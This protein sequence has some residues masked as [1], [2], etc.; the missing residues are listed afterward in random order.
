[1][2]AP[3][4]CS[5][6]TPRL[7]HTR[8]ADCVPL[9]TGPRVEVHVLP[10]ALHGLAHR[11]EPRNATHGDQRVRLGG[12]PNLR[13]GMQ[14]LQVALKR[15]E[16]A[17]DE[18]T[19]EL[20]LEQAVVV[21]RAAVESADAGEMQVAE[22][23]EQAH[24]CLALALFVSGCQALKQKKSSD[25]HRLFD[26]AIRQRPGLGDGRRDEARRHRAYALYALGKEL[27]QQSLKQY[28]LSIRK[29]SD[30][31]MTA[32]LMEIG[33]QE[34]GDLFQEIGLAPEQPQSMSPAR[35]LARKPKELI[36]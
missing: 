22:N 25:A 8:A 20:R 11:A 30:E 5:N 32:F 9:A 3:E 35:N 26:E 13:D 36:V 23:V 21:L 34:V 2:A 27:L 29:L 33:L 10:A 28:S 1:M 15:G 19:R 16:G 12:H 17:L 31:A 18:G 6:A 24:R 7:V 14:H 4:V